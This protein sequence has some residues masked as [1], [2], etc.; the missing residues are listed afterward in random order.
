[1]KNTR[2]GSMIIVTTAM[3]FA[4]F[5]GL[6][7]DE[8]KSSND[9]LLLATDARDAE[10]PVFEEAIIAKNFD[11]LRYL[12]QMGERGCEKL[13]PHLK[14]SNQSLRDAAGASLAYCQ[15][16]KLS[17]HIM[18]AFEE[19]NGDARL[20]WL[21]ALGFSGGIVGRNAL[22]AMLGEA[23]LSDKERADVAYALMQNIVYARAKATDLPGFDAAPLIK[24]ITDGK[25][26]GQAA[27]L[28]ARLQE[29]PTVWLAEDF[30]SLLETK[31]K[32]A[33]N[34]TIKERE[35]VRVMVRLA[36]EY[37]NSSAS[38]LLRIAKEMQGS[39]AMEA[40][41]SMSRLSDTDT[42]AYLLA[43]AD[44]DGEPAMRHL[45]VEALGGRAAKDEALVSVIGQYV[46]DDNRWVAATALRALGRYE[47]DT[48]NQVAAEWLAGDDYYL[49]FMGL[50]ALTGSDE[51]KMLLQEYADANKD[52]VR[53]Y[54]AAVALDPSIEGNVE[55]RKTPPLGLVDSYSQRLLVL[56]TSKG[57][58]CIDATGDAPFAYTNFL[59]LAD[60]GKMDGMLWHRVIPNFVAQAGQIENPELSKWGAIREE[61]GGE[62]KIGTVGVATAGR[63]TGSVQ[64]FI[65]T[66]FN[67][68]LTERYTVFGQV[69]KGMEH[70]FRLEEGDVITKASTERKGYDGC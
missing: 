70:V 46:G 67:R 61:W 49:A 19:L 7:A 62:H 56:D 13:L 32:A 39:L 12:G 50:L 58:V 15:D 5:C 47:P 34:Q 28:L 11:S 1:M 6:Q 14:S 16:D 64:F 54:E 41:R 44:S 27:Y 68:H 55:P 37:G 38:I 66:G 25:N 69:T 65:N 60:Y 40:V 59:S 8:K 23:G 26:D 30:Y 53:G 45:A 42:R 43:L 52:T 4:G 24:M 51:G 57:R 35:P 10:S 22:V 33:K 17:H 3:S 20:P 48:A 36:R 2:L 63:D 29:L 31:L 21:K 18:A 9:E